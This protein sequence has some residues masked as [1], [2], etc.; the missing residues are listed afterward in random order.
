MM[1]PITATLCAAVAVWSFGTAAYAEDTGY[2]TTSRLPSKVVKDINQAAGISVD[3]S[4]ADIDS[5]VKD[6]DATQAAIDKQKV[7]AISLSVSGWVTQETQ[8]NLKQ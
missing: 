6:L 1:K 2:P 7:P 4:R 5:E 8:F 3:K